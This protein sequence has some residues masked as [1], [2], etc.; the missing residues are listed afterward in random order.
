MREIILLGKCLGGRGSVSRD[1]HAAVD[2]LARRP[3][4]ALVAVQ[5][6]SPG[7]YGCAG[8]YIFISVTTVWCGDP[9]QPLISS[10]K[11][12]VHVNL[13]GFGFALFSNDMRLAW[14]YPHGSTQ[15]VFA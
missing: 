5:T 13:M 9:E 10:K 6:P 7:A 2:L 4:S 3:D 12:N 1:A 15:R 8:D 14:G 11:C